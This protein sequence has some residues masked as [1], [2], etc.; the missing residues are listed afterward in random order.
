MDNE[1]FMRVECAIRERQEQV[2]RAADRWHL[3]GDLPQ[4]PALRER[5]ARLFLALAA[6]L[7]P[8]GATP[9]RAHRPLGHAGHS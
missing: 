3:A 9:V 8:S 4:D 2:S 7:D 1:T 6:W 5:L